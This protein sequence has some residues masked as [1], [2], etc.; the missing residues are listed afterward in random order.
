MKKIAISPSTTVEELIEQY[1][2]SIGF[3]MERGIICVR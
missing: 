1:P 3:L 2:A